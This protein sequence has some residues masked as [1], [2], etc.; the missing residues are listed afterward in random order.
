M[1][2]RRT[3]AADYINS[4]RCSDTEILIAPGS[5]DLST[6]R[7]VYKRYLRNINL[8]EADLPS[9]DSL[10]VAGGLVCV[11][12]ARYRLG[13]QTLYLVQSLTSVRRSR[14]PYIGGSSRT[15]TCILVTTM[16]AQS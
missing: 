9:T 1:A 6:Y 4:M 10:S 8:S 7:P 2:L 15:A 13:D 5:T 3:T 14:Q 11:S 12:F 16:A